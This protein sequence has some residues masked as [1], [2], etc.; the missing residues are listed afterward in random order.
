M[1]GFSSEICHITPAYHLPLGNS[2]SLSWLSYFVFCWHLNLLFLC[3]FVYVSWKQKENYHCWFGRKYY[4]NRVEHVPHKQNFPTS[5]KTVKALLTSIQHGCFDRQHEPT[6]N[7]GEQ[8]KLTWHKL[9]PGESILLG[10]TLVGS[11]GSLLTWPL[12]QWPF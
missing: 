3:L 8:L 6:A 2:R 12:C 7:I 9:L 4:V 5:S 11:L 10:K 1:I